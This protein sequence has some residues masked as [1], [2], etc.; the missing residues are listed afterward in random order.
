MTT[1]LYATMHKFN[2]VMHKHSARIKNSV[3][4]YARASR[5]APCK[6]NNEIN[7]TQNEVSSHTCSTIKI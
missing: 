6:E 2:T 5:T 3:N 7:K 4:I 1:V